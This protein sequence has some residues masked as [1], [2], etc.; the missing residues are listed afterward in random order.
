MVGI[1]FNRPLPEFEGP[2]IHLF[3]DGKAKQGRSWTTAQY[4]WVERPIRRL[5][6]YDH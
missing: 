6:G 4:R 3:E 1:L 5:Q 2:E